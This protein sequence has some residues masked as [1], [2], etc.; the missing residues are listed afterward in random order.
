MALVGIYNENDFYSHHYLSEVFVGDIRGVLEQWLEKENQAREIERAEKEQGGK[1]Q[2][3]YRA[4]HTQLA[5]YS[6]EYFRELNQHLSV[7]DINKRLSN[8][9]AR[10]SPILHALGFEIKPTQVLLE[11]GQLPVLSAYQDHQGL[12]LLWILEAHDPS[13]D[14]CA[15]PLS[16]PLLSQQL[17]ALEPEQRKVLLKTQQGDELS[18]QDLISKKIFSAPEPPRWL[19]LLGNR[20]CLLLDRTKW[21][22]NRL[23]RFD[24]EE[25]LGRKESDTLKAMA[26][27]L[28]KDSICPQQGQNLLDNLDESSHKHAFSVSEDLKYALRESIELLGDEAAKQ[29][30]EKGFTYDGKNN[31]D[32]SQLSLE[33]LR[34]MYRMLFLFY[35]EARPELKYAP[36]NSDVYLK[37]YS[38]EALR[39]LEMVDLSTEESR[40]GRYIHDSLQM[41]FR[42]VAKGFAG[43]SK[44]S[45]SESSLF[46]DIQKS[47]A[48][49]KLESHL[50]D[51]AR[52]PYLARVVFRNETLQRVIKLMSLSRPGKG[53]GKRR[54]RISYAQLGINQLGAVYEALLS[55]RGFFAQTDLYEVKKAGEELNELETGYFVSAEQLAEYQDDE[56]V[57]RKDG[58]L[59]SHP[60]GSFIYR[61]A[62]RDR[63]KSASYYTPEVLTQ[64]LVKYALKELYKEQLEP[65]ATVAEQADKILTI[66][67]CEPAMGSAAFLNEAINQL[68]EKYLELK[69]LAEDTRIPQE[70]YTRELQRV[71]MYIADNNVYGVDLNPVAVELAEVSLWLN[72]ISDEAF[73]PWFGYQ[74]YNG[75]SLIGARR[76][77]FSTGDLT[78]TKAKDPSWL[79]IEP[80][81]LG[82]NEARSPHEVYHYLLPDNGMANYSD[83]VVKALKPTEIATINAW[84]KTFVRSFSMEEKDQLKRICQKIDELWQA[85]VEQRRKERNIT[86]DNLQI[87]PNSARSAQRSSTNDKDKLLSQS[88]QSGSAVYPRLKMVMDYW[89]ALWFWPM[90]SADDLPSRA[91]YLGEIEQVLE[92][93]AETASLNLVE[94]GSGQ[95]GMFDEMAESQTQDLFATNNSG[96]VN[97]D[98]LYMVF[99]RLALV[100]KLAARYKFFHWELELADI[101]ADHGGFDLILGNPPWLRVE[102]QE[103]G[104]MGDFEPQFVLRKFSASKLNTLR[105]EMLLQMPALEHAYFSEYEEA[106]ATQNFLNSLANYP[107]LKGSKANLYKCFLPLSWSIGSK[108]GTAGLL[109]PE[110]VYDDPNGG[111]LR[112]EIYKRLR[113]HAQFQNQ[114]MLFPIGHRNKYS[115]NIFTSRENDTVD[116]INVSNLFLPKTLDLSIHHNGSGIVGGIKNDEGNWDESGHKNRLLI[117]DQDT[118]KLFSQLYDEE[119]TPSLEARLPALHS[120]QLLSVLEKLASQP[121][122]L[123]CIRKSFVTTQHWNEVNAQKDGTI[124]RQTCHPDHT[125]SFVLS[126]PHFYVGTPVYKTPRAICTEKGHYDIVDLQTIPDNYLPRT[127]YV[128][129]CDEAEYLRRTPKVPWIDEADLAAWQ[130][131]GAKPEEMPEPRPVTDYYRFV[132]R[133]MIGPSSERTM[134]STIIPKRVGHIN[135]CLGTVF[136]RHADLLDYFGMTLSV[137][138][139]YRVKSTGMGHAN[140]TLI[141]QLPVLSNDI[142]RVAIHLRSLA[143]VALTT[144]Y[145]ELWGKCFKAQFENETWAKED[146]RLPNRFFRNLT[147]EWRRDCALRTDYARRQALVEIDVLVAMALGM[148]LEE[149]K[150]IY[151]VQFPVM[152]QYEADTWYDRTGRIVFTA[153]KGLVGVGLDRKF[154]KKNGFTLSI[155][156]GVF[157]D[158]TSGQGSA[159]EPWTQSNVALGWEDIRE[160]KSGKVYKTYMDDTQPGGPV[161][162]T[163]E[164][165]A[166]FDKCDR[167]QDYETAWAVFSERFA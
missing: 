11:N 54:G 39:D 91:E 21:A 165:I 33:C 12:P 29:L 56:K 55:Y 61:M 13:M 66:K 87:W 99:P 123:S 106:S 46:D 114:H 14:D 42:L 47:F 109:H 120:T 88:Q 94:S 96:T 65:L 35:I 45:D 58:T 128:P 22:Q 142:Y 163:I 77:V 40:N 34:Y 116:F 3:G 75:N 167:E 19:L 130:E 8:Q 155:E 63:E 83:K 18:W 110:G 117:I 157:A 112:A 125:G 140:T 81:R 159:A 100:D 144:A 160:L 148:T 15:D 38:L 93:Y 25:I 1:P 161:E 6:G 7:K 118:L 16:L 28:H 121:K 80:K 92:G 89:C 126:G 43:N 113:L 145:Q 71:K 9:R 141:N 62:G 129:A 78:Y 84:R 107:E 105:E 31:I 23:L 137:P 50:F 69:Q 59:L 41:L 72:A 119:G 111:R 70:Q 49:R 57:F 122:K 32:A 147:A 166:P 97:K 90:E 60:K 143:L 154:N 133:E 52:M 124:E 98:F 37:G 36:T 138:I 153:S 44:Q 115:V 85:H 132:N 76:Q 24:L 135:T 27:L 102:W 149:L 152:R 17:E 108:N 74:L 48:I 103:S 20:Q 164:Y 131:K 162:R 82:H 2:R 26:A 79:N 104:I 64:S 151:R 73:V 136:K 68:A 146:S 150:T 101:F 5:S 134:I 53:K 158:K 86:T 67:V 30:I 10:W 127:N 95:L 139:D 156:D 51:D 4:P